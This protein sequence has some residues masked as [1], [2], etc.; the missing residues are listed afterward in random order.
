MTERAEELAEAWLSSPLRQEL[1]GARPSPEVPFVLAIGET[2]VRG[3]IDLLAERRDGSVCVVDYKTDRLEGRDPA[4]V[5]SRYEVQRDLYAL[6][7]ATR[8]TPVETAYVFLEQPDAAV[9][10]TFGPE[11]LAAARERVEAVL[12]RLDEGRF[13]VTHH[14]HRA[15][16]HDCPA[17]ERLC[18]HTMEAK[19]RDDPEPPIS[20]PAAVPAE[21]V[22][23]A[24]AAE[25]APDDADGPAQLTLL[26]D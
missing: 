3:S 1:D 15:L 10:T 17:K 8:G 5:A 25:A 16:C 18:S 14:P 6:A 19:M 23:E 4:Q 20:P 7:A 9:R 2:L 12:A 26:G 11:E 13:E 22:V 24:T 21:P